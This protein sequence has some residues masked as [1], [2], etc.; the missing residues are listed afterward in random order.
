VADAL[1]RAPISAVPEAAD[2][3]TSVEIEFQAPESP[4]RSAVRGLD[5]KT[6]SVAHDTDPSAS[7]DED[8]GQDPHWRTIWLRLSHGQPSLPFVL[9]QG[10]I[11][12]PKPGG[13]EGKRLCVPQA[14]VSEVLRE[15]HS[16]IRAA[17]PGVHGTVEL[18]SGTCSSMTCAR[19]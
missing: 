1:S 17:H 18:T 9:D 14:R 13:D 4:D 11:W 6:D 5:A 16:S 8:Y 15:Y 19:R 2:Q 3:E 10:R 12:L 7:W